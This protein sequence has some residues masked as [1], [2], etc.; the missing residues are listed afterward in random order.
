[1]GLT[2]T[3]GTVASNPLPPAPRKPGSVGL[4]Y[5]NEIIIADDQGRECA[6]QEVGEL[7]VRVGVEAWELLKSETDWLSMSIG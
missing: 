7:L 1:M 2:E 5:G 6:P 4:P 3:A